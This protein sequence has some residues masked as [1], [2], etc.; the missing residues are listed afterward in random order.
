MFLPFYIVLGFKS[1]QLVYFIE[2]Q[3]LPEPLVKNNS[4]SIFNCSCLCFPM[5]NLGI[6]GHTISRP[7]PLANIMQPTK[8]AL[9][10]HLTTWRRGY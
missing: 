8:S 9:L 1:I 3:C 7:T 6:Y 2:P 10:S 5:M 4:S